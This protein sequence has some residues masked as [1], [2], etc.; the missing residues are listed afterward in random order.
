MIHGRKIDLD[1][2]PLLSK[3]AKEFEKKPIKTSFYSQLTSS[4]ASFNDPLHINS[5]QTTSIVF[6]GNDDEQFTNSNE[7]NNNELSNNIIQNNNSLVSSSY[8][9]SFELNVNSFSTFNRINSISNATDATVN[10]AN[11]TTNTKNSNKKSHLRK[12]FPLDRTKTQYSFLNI[13]ENIAD[14]FSYMTLC[15]ATKVM[16][17]AAFRAYVKLVFVINGILI[18]CIDNFD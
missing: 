3:P 11:A 6:N 8:F 15:R 9:D 7:T 10:D 12:L 5:S 16:N 17:Q 1:K 4:S 2:C 13:L 14:I 18:R